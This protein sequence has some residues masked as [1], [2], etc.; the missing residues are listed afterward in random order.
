MKTTS[1]DVKVV[2][3]CSYAKRL[4]TGKDEFKD[5]IAV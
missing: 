4:M 3:V 1:D 2:P 5:V